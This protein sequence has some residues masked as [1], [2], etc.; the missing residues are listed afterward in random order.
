MEGSQRLNGCGSAVKEHQ[1]GAG[2]RYSLVPLEKVLQVSPCR[3]YEVEEMLNPGWYLSH[4][5]S[6]KSLPVNFSTWNHINQ[7]IGGDKNFSANSNR[8]LTRLK[9]VFITLQG[10][11]GAWDKQCNDLFQPIVVKTTDAY[12]VADEHQY[13]V[14]IGS[15]LIPE[16]LAKSLSESLSQLRKTVGG[17]FQMFGRWYRTRKYII[18]FDIEQISGAGFTGMST[19]AGDLVTLNFRDCAVDGLGGSIPQRVY[20]CLNYDVVIN[21]IDPGCDM[22]D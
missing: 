8:A 15:K 5:L 13:H 18:G 21:I 7:S 14:Q 3:S 16:H 22:L 10:T 6:G 4:L 11:E 1:S 20:C 19:K 9:P 12:S 2:S 17:S